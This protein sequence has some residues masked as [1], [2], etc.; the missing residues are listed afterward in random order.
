MCRI[1][2]RSRRRGNGFGGHDDLAD[3]SHDLRLDNLRLDNLGVDN[4]GVDN[5]RLDNLGLRGGKF[6]LWGGTPSGS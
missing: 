6:H 5:L 2:G 1:P 4:L 3:I